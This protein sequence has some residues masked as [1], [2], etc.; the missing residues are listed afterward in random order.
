LDDV[1]TS[2]ELEVTA[3]ETGF[4]KRKS[5]VTPSVFFD[6]LMYD[7]NSGNSKSLNQ[8]SIEALSEH[9]VE[10]TKQ[11]VDKKF[12]E[13]TLEFLKSLIEKQLSVELDNQIDAGWLSSFTR[14]TIRDGSR[15]K[16]PEEYKDYF[17]GSGGSGSSAGACLQFEFDLK[18]G[19]VTDLD[20]TASNRP[21]VKDALELLDNVTKGDLVIRDLGYYAFKSFKNIIE[22][23]AFF[24]SRL[25][26]KSTV[27][28]VICGDYKKLDFKTVYDQ[29]KRDKQSSTYKDVFIGSE[30]KIPVRLVID[31]MPDDVYEQRMRKIRK[32]HKKKGYKTSEEYKFIARFNLFITN[33]PKEVLPDEVISSLYR[34]RWQ[35]ELIFKIWKSVI[36]IHHTRKMKHQRWLCLLHFK[37]LMMIVNWNIIMTQRNYL[38]RRKGKLL[39]LNKC[40]KT[41][42]DNT[43]RLRETLRLGQKG[44]LKYLKW[45]NRILNENHW[46]ERK[47]NKLGLEKIFYIMFC[48]SNVYVYI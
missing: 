15:F 25:G 14:V 10:V 1:F 30:E 16:L 12:N 9:D 33:V 43:H 8:L 21:D 45:A 37:L 6:L 27:F 48:K 2:E 29:M 4:Y 11:G 31:L 41:L 17:P 40:F 5:K 3:R 7:M 22:K 18:S 47:K 44:V 39:S 26:V 34:M 28:E 19:Q 46:L 35:I 23:E 13:H 32:Q 36:G 24:I 20:L 38:Y 42:F